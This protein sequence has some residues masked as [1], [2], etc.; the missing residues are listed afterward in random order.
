[1]NLHLKRFMSD[2]QFGA[3][4]SFTKGTMKKKSSFS[5]LKRD[6]FWQYPT[7][8]SIRCAHRNNF[9]P[10][11]TV[12]ENFHFFSWKNQNKWVW[13]FLSWITI[14]LSSICL[15]DCLS[16]CLSI[17]IYIYICLVVFCLF[18]NLSICLSLFLFV[19][20]FVYIYIYISVCLF[21]YMFICLWKHCLFS[22]GFPRKFSLLEIFTYF[23]VFFL[24]LKYWIQY[25]HF[26]SL[27]FF[28]SLFLSFSLS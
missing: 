12:N 8:F 11:I 10:R 21:I 9:F 26:L 23:I 19:Y 2:S 13:Q 5:I 22:P 25:L 6:Q 20:L 27:S 1:M 24:D 28:P 14:W 18:I 15:S 17:C 7:F 3:L 16:V 4:H